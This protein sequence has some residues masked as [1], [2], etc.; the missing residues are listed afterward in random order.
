VEFRILGPLEVFDGG[1][2][3]PLGGERQR[4][5]LAILLL[6][7][8]EPVSTDRLLDELWGGKPPAA[9]STALRVRVSQLRKALGDAGVLITRPPGYLL[10][11][12]AGELDLHRFEALVSE[13]DRVEPEIAAEKLREALR[14]W[15]GEPLADF[16][17]E[18]FA[19]PAIGRLEEL[20]L[21]AVE[22]RV[23]A[24]LA[25]G[26]HAQLAPELRELVCAHPLRERLRA[27]LMLCLYRSG[28]QAEALEVYQ[29]ARRTL[30]ELLGID[31]SPALQELERAIL[32]QDGSLEP[33]RI[34]GPTRSILVAARSDAELDSLVALAEPLARRP[35]RDVILAQVARREDLQTAGERLASRRE[36]LRRRGVTSRVAA[37]T[38]GDPARDVVRLATEQDVDLVLLAGRMSPEVEVVFAQ[39][40]CDAALLLDGTRPPSI[41]PGWPVL[42]PF[43]GADHDWA[44]VELA[45]WLAQAERAPLCLVGTTGSSEGGDASR[46]LASVS[47]IVQR[48]A[49]IDVTSTLVEHGEQG[50]VR[51]AERAGLIVFGLSA[52][53]RGK[54]AGEST[55]RRRRS[56]RERRVCRSLTRVVVGVPAHAATPSSGRPVPP[57]DV[58][59]V[60]RQALPAR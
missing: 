37:F 3:L 59:A 53:W 21:L 32:R 22:K 6:R 17:Y 47:L 16:A 27:Q 58:N 30:V 43:G 29:D 24:D 11:V 55:E 5:L 19:Q 40:P 52:G 57:G 41:G 60:I 10:R 14:L 31:P 51:A 12:R 50:L 25:L 2:P 9:R 4:G 8:N 28:R 15:R 1:R 44:A 36:A 13:A 49:A 23:E 46:L 33:E 48:I 56:C 34:V 18:S 35:A 39:A 26:R 54:G 42:V 20:R 38:S 7:A 45:T